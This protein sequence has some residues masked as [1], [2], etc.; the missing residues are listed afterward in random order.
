MAY[1]YNVLDNVNLTLHG[2]YTHV[3]ISKVFG[4]NAENKICLPGKE[5]LT[6][7]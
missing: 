7:H 4:I 6:S 5:Y 1:K 2:H 3:Y